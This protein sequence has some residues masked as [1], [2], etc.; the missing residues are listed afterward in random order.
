MLNMLSFLDYNCSCKLHR[1]DHASCQALFRFKCLIQIPQ[2]P[3]T[4]PLYYEL[5]PNAIQSYMYYFQPAI[6]DNFAPGPPSQSTSLG[7]YGP[8]A[9]GSSSAAV[10]NVSRAGLCIAG[11]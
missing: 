3:A 6:S 1:L 8:F 7:L 11:A 5:V 10:L 2:F 9:F 4:V